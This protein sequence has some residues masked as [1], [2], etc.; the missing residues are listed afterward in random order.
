MQNIHFRY[1]Y[2]SEQINGLPMG[3]IDD[4][5]SYEQKTL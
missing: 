1:G 4:S 5:D 3:F 2:S